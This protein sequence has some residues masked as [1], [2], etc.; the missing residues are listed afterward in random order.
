MY[1]CLFLCHLIKRY[2]PDING[3]RNECKETYLGKIL[4]LETVK[5]QKKHIKLL[6][7]SL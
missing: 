2:Y 1:N 6:Y 7:C 3:I 5:F 4:N